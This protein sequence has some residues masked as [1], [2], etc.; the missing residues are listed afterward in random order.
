M[1]RSVSSKPVLYLRSFLFWIFFASITIVFALLLLLSFPFPFEKRFIL[2]HTWSKLT[3]W[4]LG[5]TC[6]LYYEVQG[7]ENIRHGAGIVFAKHQSTWE[8]LTLNFWFSPQTWVIK[9]E[10]MWLPFF[11]WGA[12]MMEPI[13]LNRGAGRK[14]IEQLVSQGQKRLDGGRWIIIFP[15]GTRIAPGK[16]GRYRIGGAVLAE[17][18]GYP[19]YPV[20][21]NAG[22]YWPRRQF[23]KMPGVIKVRIGPAILPE[24]KSAQQ[25]LAAAEDWI[26]TQMA[27]ITTLAKHEHGPVESN[28]GASD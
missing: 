16:R 7:Q 10:L 21:H 3:I 1:Q 8:T 2:T 4:W 28:Q 9:R 17:R 13:A 24:G 20:A 15:E 12:Y 19:V 27:Q 14:A 25:I 5:A 11:G 22:E 18:T 23:I 26:E 6:K